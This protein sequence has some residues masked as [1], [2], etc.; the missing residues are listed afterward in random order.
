MKLGK[1]AGSIWDMEKVDL[2][3]VAMAELGI[4]IAQAERETVITLR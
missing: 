2:M 4:T 1:E 3:E